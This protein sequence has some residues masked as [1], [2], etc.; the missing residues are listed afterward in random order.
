[1]EVSAPQCVGPEF[2][3]LKLLGVTYMAG[4][5]YH[6]QAPSLTSLMSGLKS[7]KLDS[8]MTVNWGTQQFGFSCSMRIVRPLISHLYTALSI[9]RQ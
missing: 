9:S 8:A 2:R 5:W 3:I 4:S 6:L 7:Q 1:M